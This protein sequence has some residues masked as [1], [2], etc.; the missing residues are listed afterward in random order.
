MIY[1]TINNFLIVLVFMNIENSQ[2]NGF[3]IIHDISTRKKP[4]SDVSKLFAETEHIL[5]LIHSD[6]TNHKELANRLDSM[7]DIFLKCTKEGT[8]ELSLEEKVDLKYAFTDILDEVNLKMHQNANIRNSQQKGVT[9][10]A[11]IDV[12]IRLAS[13]VGNLAFRV[14]MYTADVIFPNAPDQF[15]FRTTEEEVI[16]KIQNAFGSIEHDKRFEKYEAQLME[17]RKMIQTSLKGEE[18]SLGNLAYNFFK[19]AKNPEELAKIR[20]QEKSIEL[21][22]R[23]IKVKKV[24]QAEHLKKTEN[25]SIARPKYDWEGT[26]DPLLNGAYEALLETKGIL[27]GKA[28]EPY[29]PEK[30]LSGKSFAQLLTSTIDEE[31][32]KVG[33]VLN[34]LS[35]AIGEPVLQD[36]RKR[37]ADNLKL[38]TEDYNLARFTINMNNDTAKLF[39]ALDQMKPESTQDDL[40][41]ALNIV[42]ENK[43]PLTAEE[44]MKMAHEDIISNICKLCFIE[45][46][47]ADQDTVE[48]LIK[49]TW[50]KVGNAALEKTIASIIEKCFDL[51][52]LKDVLGQIPRLPDTEKAAACWG[53]GDKI[54]KHM[55]VIALFL[56]N[57]LL[58]EMATIASE[59]RTAQRKNLPTDVSALPDEKAA[60]K[61]KQSALS[62]VRVLRNLTLPTESEG[63]KILKE[64]GL[65]S[66][67][68]GALT[69]Y[70]TF[71]FVNYMVDAQGGGSLKD[72]ASPAYK[73]LIK[74]WTDWA[75]K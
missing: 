36:I 24:M 33:K 41:K 3:N 69:N 39:S 51:K 46:K 43:V 4:G 14:F 72:I 12:N 57:K 59:A 11:P 6:S 37:L 73:E 53:G 45:Q 61:A 35:L 28:L 21:I 20:E 29:T 67:M 31:T 23:S 17:K 68:Y 38:I 9:G 1:V 49:S 44:F 70:L 60:E 15:E 65:S 54:N 63:N 13:Y 71:S 42:D 2:F 34:G 58:A 75:S 22:D 8:S 16:K 66:L 7:K 55:D 74:K 47:E 48:G 30:L 64:Q 26:F 10:F 50:T 32:S 52:D 5:K 27:I 56:A 62:L 25:L 40:I 19:I 18:S